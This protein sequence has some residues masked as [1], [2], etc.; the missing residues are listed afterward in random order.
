MRFRRHSIEML[1]QMAPHHGDESK[2]I[3]LSR[4]GRQHSRNVSRERE[5]QRRESER[6]SAGWSAPAHDDAGD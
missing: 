1:E 3:S 6:R 4:Q 5:E 2:L